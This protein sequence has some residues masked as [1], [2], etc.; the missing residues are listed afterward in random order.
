MSWSDSFV[1]KKRKKVWQLGLLCLF[2]QFGRLGTGLLFEMMCCPYKNSTLLLFLIWLE[3][4]LSIVDGPSTLVEF[5]DW[6]G[7]K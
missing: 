2:E 5:I 6:V 4:K 1:S 3:T 7:C